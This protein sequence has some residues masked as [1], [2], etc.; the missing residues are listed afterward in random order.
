MEHGETRLSLKE[1]IA[2]QYNYT[3]QQFDLCH[4]GN[5]LAEGVTMD[6]LGIKTKDIVEFRLTDRRSFS[7]HLT[8]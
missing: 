7:P 5:I 8:Q 4:N 3:L 1:A 2:D 6:D